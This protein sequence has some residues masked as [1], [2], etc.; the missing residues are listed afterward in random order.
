MFRILLVVENLGSKEE[1]IEA[2]AQMRARK[3]SIKQV[4]VKLN[5][6]VSGE[7]NAVIDLTDLPPVAGDA[8]P[9]REKAHVRG[10]PSR[11]AVRV[12]GSYLR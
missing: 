4:L 3:P 12:R 10:T 5:E 8:D 9:G 1:L 11:H 6:G 2:I 7:G